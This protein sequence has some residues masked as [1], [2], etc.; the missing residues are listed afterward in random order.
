MSPLKRITTVLLASSLLALVLMVFYLNF[1]LR[2]SAVQQWVGNRSQSVRLLSLLVDDE[3]VEARE[4]LEFAA[5]SDPFQ[6]PLDPSLIDLSVNGIPESV[7][8]NRRSVLDGL[9]SGKKHGF[10]VI[11]ILLPNGDHYLSHPFSVQESLKTYNL[12]HR[13]YFQE[14]VKTRQ[15][16]ISNRFLGADGLP[17]VAIDIPVLND[18]GNIIFHLGGVFHLSRAGGLVAQQDFIDDNDATFL[19]DGMGEVITHSGRFE[20][21]LEKELFQAITHKELYLQPSFNVSETQKF[22]PEILHY[23]LGESKKIIIMSSLECGWTLGVVTDLDAVAAFFQ[24]SVNRTAVFAGLLLLLISSAAFFLVHRIGS[25]WEVSDRYLQDSHDRLAKSIEGHSMELS[26]GQVAKQKAENALRERENLF[27]AIT[28]QSVE[29]ITVADVEGKY[30]FVNPAFCKMMGYSEEE[31]LQM[32]VFDVKAKSQDKSSFSRSKKSKEGLP[33]QVYLQR[34][35][36]TEFFSEVLGKM[37]DIG[38]K[39]AVLG[40]VRDITER[41]HNDEERINLER[42]LQHAQ[43]LESLGVLAGG[44]AH[45]FNNLLMAI[46]G[47]ADLALNELSPMSPAR[48]NIKEIESASRRAAELARQMLAYSGKGRFVVQPISLDEMVGEIA[49]L[50]EV[51][52]SKKVVLKFNFAHNL[53]TFDGDVTQVRQIVMNLITNASEAVG[54]QSGVV[55]LS[56]GAMDCDR[57]YLDNANTTLSAGTDDP[58]EEGIYTY[59]EVSDT[60]CGMDRV[61]LGKIFDPFFTTKF[62]G[63]GLGMSAVQ[64]IVRGHRGAIMVNSEVGKGTT[65]KILFKANELAVDDLEPASSAASTS[66]ELPVQFGGTVLIVDDEDTVCAVGK[67]MLHRMGFQV[68]TA[69]DG[70]EGVKLFETHHQE[71]TCVLLDLTMPHMD[72]QQT[73]VAMQR[74]DPEVTVILCSGYNEIDAIQSFAVKGLAGFIQKPYNMEILREKLLEVLVAD[75]KDV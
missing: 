6:F 18:Q 69:P 48:D 71:I 57:T 75:Q 73:F 23:P 46:L 19:L 70:R 27:D 43:K 17:A 41:M 40:T 65:F 2:E 55:S 9:L 25:G 51:S 72:G 33:I 11:F 20:A 26:A 39:K 4:K 10:D 28:T 68:L 53:P 54:N 38:D 74:V 16:V 59:L 42:Q 1:S 56:T 8:D 30:T 35:D 32:T 5:H 66:D 3:L 34:K 12:S 64:G 36:G 29:G 13:P 60:G 15:P 67:Q 47:N 61:T 24:P 49:H 50:L 37:I 14:A 21:G 58:L 22:L 44:I 31:L 7:Q 45:D 63:R 62:T 52:I